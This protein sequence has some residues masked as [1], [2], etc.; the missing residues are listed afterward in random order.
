M[1]E[2]EFI[3][4]SLIGWNFGDG[5]LH[6]ERLISAVQERCQYEPGDLVVAFTESQPIH[7]NYIEYRVIDAALGVVERGTYVVKDA[8]DEL[9]WLPNG[10]I[11]HE[12]TWQLPGYE[13]PGDV[14]HGIG[15]R[16][17]R[18]PSRPQPC[19]RRLRP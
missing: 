12:V 18:T 6:D 10:P 4:N 13:A 16:G 2:A 3:C 8:T 14:L 19:R 15:V 11:R 9:P 17:T 5:H 1:R 7:K